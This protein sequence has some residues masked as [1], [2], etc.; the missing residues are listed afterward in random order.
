MFISRY[1]AFWRFHIIK[2]GSYN[3]T[4]YWEMIREIHLFIDYRVTFNLVCKICTH[5]YM[6]DDRVITSWFLIIRILNTTS[7]E[8]TRYLRVYLRT[9]ALETPLSLSLFLSTL[10]SQLVVAPSM[11]T[12]LP[13]H[14]KH[15]KE[16]ALCS[17]WPAPPSIFADDLIVSSRCQTVQSPVVSWLRDVRRAWWARAAGSI[18]LKWP[19]RVSPPTYSFI[20]VRQLWEGGD[21]HVSIGLTNSYQ[22]MP[23]IRIWCIIWKVSSFAISAFNSVHVSKTGHTMTGHTNCRCQT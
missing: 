10:D 18:R 19:K 6:I 11:L 17:W 3:I 13:Q 21:F 5:K 7:T 4:R 14:S 9:I 22:K 12:D 1:T 8:S 20:Y 15:Q 16:R 23:S 2:S